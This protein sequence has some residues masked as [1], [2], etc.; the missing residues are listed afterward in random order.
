MF[1][2]HSLFHGIADA[3]GSDSKSREILSQFTEGY[4]FIRN[5]AYL[6]LQKLFWEELQHIYDLSQVDA[7]LA[8]YVWSLLYPIGE[9]WEK[10]REIEENFLAHLMQEVEKNPL[11][12]EEDTRKW[13]QEKSKMFFRFEKEKIALSSRQK[14]N[15][16][17]IY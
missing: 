1:L 12:D 3:F 9:D 5:E 10:C 14:K 7:L 2:F 17:K 13:I 6:R 8:P 11:F 15:N 16:Y 4:Y